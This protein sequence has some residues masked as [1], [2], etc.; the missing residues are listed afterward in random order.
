M[1]TVEDLKRDHRITM[2]I[3]RAQEALVKLGYTEHG[4]RHMSKVSEDA[5][6]IMRNL[7]Y[8]ERDVGLAEI[9]G[10]L[11][12]IGSAVNRNQHEQTGAILALTYLT[13]MGMPFQDALDVATAIGNHHEETGEPVTAITAAVILADKADVHRSRVVA[14]DIE[15]DIH[16]RVN[17][18][19]TDSTIEVD[20]TARVISYR[21]EIDTEISPVMEYFE[22]FTP[23]IHIAERAARALSAS[24]QVWINGMRML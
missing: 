22:I 16:D 13:G 12:D 7:G 24:F 15:H 1:I 18:A 14:Y 3:S 17:F 2:L 8:P 11:H 19:A 23:R 6:K 5:G 9:A 10:Y 20:P 21:I 4:E